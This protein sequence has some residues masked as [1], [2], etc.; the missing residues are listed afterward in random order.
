LPNFQEEKTR[1]KEYKEEGS[2]RKEVGT[3]EKKN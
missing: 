1:R 3:K 2:V